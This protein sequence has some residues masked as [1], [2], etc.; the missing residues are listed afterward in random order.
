M[1][2]GDN[3]QTCLSYNSYVLYYCIIMI[4]D[5]NVH[6]CAFARGYE[7]S[8]AIEH[9]RVHSTLSPPPSSL[10]YPPVFLL[11]LPLPPSLSFTPPPS[12]SLSF[13]LPPSPPSS[14]SLLP[15]PPSPSLLLPLPPPHPS[16]PSLLLTPLNITG[17]LIN[18]LLLISVGVFFYLF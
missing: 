18:M 15:L 14:P 9:Y 10:P 6:D 11:P 3:D 7:P 1:F 8:S 12:P 2:T 16:S 5:P 4:N 17:V 13:P